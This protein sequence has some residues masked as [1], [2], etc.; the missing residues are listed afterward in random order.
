MNTVEMGHM[1]VEDV[2]TYLKTNRTIILPYGV[3]E[4]HGYHLPL[5]TDIRNAEVMGRK[6]A[7][8]IG[9]IV[10]P[11][12]N[13]CFSG[14]MLEGTINVR[15][16][17]FSTMVCEII[18]SLVVQG[19]ENII[20]LPGHGGSESLL[21]LKE[22]L[23]IMKWLNEATKDAMILLPQM[24]T[25]SPTWLEMFKNSDFHAAAAE[26]SLAM[27]W[28]P[29]LVRET[30]ATDEEEIAEMLRSDPDSY[31]VRTR[32][33]DLSDEIVS[34][35]QNDRIKVGVMG[36]P[37][38]ATAAAGRKIETEMLDSLGPLLKQAVVNADLRRKR[39]E[40]IIVN[41]DEKLR[42]LSL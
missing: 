33:N 38:E 29:E 1:T 27:Y 37:E 23:R 36:Y 19:F 28:A 8:K 42:I 13:Y 18:E 24:W 31:Q 39:G 30:R 22:S 15:P 11:T 2:R 4:Q 25:Y 41:D 35:S 12:L 32:F 34:T 26:T 5:D 9:C 7:E 20:V 6:L 14:G 17:T 40:S 10:A 21:H 3:V 16:N